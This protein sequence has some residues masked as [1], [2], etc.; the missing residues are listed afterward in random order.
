MESSSQTLN[1]SVR[2]LGGT[3]IKGAPSSYSHS[4]CWQ[5]FVWESLDGWGRLPPRARRVSLSDSIAP[6]NVQLVQKV[7]ENPQAFPT[8]A[9]FEY[10]PS[11][12]CRTFQYR[13]SDRCRTFQYC[14]SNRCRTFEYCPSNQCW[15]SEY[16]PSDRCRTFLYRRRVEPRRRIWR[17]ATFN[18]ILKQ[19]DSISQLEQV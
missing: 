9:A 16:R 17:C 2:L 3:R 15:T 5:R 11:D 18:A 6:R 19:I 8:P 7:Q 4:Y 10:R 14:P 13:P 12:Q 1:L